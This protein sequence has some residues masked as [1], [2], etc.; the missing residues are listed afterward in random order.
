[1]KDS[2][3]MAGPN[4]SDEKKALIENLI[5]EGERFL[6]ASKQFPATRKHTSRLSFEVSGKRV[7]VALFRLGLGIV[8]FLVIAIALNFR[9]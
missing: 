9:S 1:M 5:A 4:A 3:A 7:G 8:V 6:E 2:L